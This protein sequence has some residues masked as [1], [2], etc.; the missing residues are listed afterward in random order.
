MRTWS[1]SLT[2]GYD[3][4]HGAYGTNWSSALFGS[5]RGGVPTSHSEDATTGGSDAIQRDLMVCL[6]EGRHMCWI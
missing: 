5:Y 2:G 4:G 1:A 3:A 6:V